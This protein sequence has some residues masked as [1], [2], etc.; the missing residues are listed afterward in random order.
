[1]L[2]WVFYDRKLQTLTLLAGILE[3][4][5]DPSFL[6]SVNQHLTGVDDLSFFI[7]TKRKNLEWPSFSLL[8]VSKD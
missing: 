4:L 3:L 2:C 7:K 5:Q 1:M 8:S 6:N